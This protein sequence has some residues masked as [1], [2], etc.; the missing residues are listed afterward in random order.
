MLQPLASSDATLD[1]HRG[2]PPVSA[3]IARK[4]SR[5]RK[6]RYLSELLSLVRSRNGAA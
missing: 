1:Q 5:S 6:V 4:R 3:L 2:N